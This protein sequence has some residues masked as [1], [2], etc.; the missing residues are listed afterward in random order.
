MIFNDIQAYLTDLR[1]SNTELFASYTDS[2]LL[3]LERAEALRELRLDIEAECG[4]QPNEPYALD[5]I[6]TIHE[7]RLRKS[8]GLK[9]LIRF[10]RSLNESAVEGSQAF[11]RLALYVKEY[12]EAKRMF[13]Y[14]TF[15]NIGAMVRIEQVMR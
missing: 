7:E 13:K 2:Q 14:L 11:Y 6:A 1:G 5:T 10:Y 8:L 12:Q 15:R 4:I 3:E 9:Q